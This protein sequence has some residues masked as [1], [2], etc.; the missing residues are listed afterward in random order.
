[1]PEKKGLETD[2][3]SGEMIRRLNEYSSRIKNIELRVERLDNRIDGIEET[4]LNQLNN[5]K[6]S[7]ERLSQKISSVSDKIANIE[8]EILRIN[9]ELG[10][11]ALKSDIKKIE[12][13]IEVVNPITSKFVTREELE[14]IL[15]EKEKIES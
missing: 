8:N 13:F 10:K 7:L 11:T 15:E 12:A 2:V 3:L 6:I 1:M 9:K 4:A 14:R 5:I